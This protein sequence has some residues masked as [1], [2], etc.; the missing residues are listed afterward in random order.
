MPRK[1]MRFPS[2]DTYENL[3]TGECVQ[4]ICTTEAHFGGMPHLVRSLRE[5]SSRKGVKF[6][7][8]WKPGDG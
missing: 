7:K 5:V 3:L 8:R 2:D 1:R 6:D 4:F